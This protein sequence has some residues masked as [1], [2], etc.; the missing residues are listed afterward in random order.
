VLCASASH[1][2]YHN[3]ISYTNAILWR[4]FMTDTVQFCICVL[5]LLQRGHKPT[6][7]YILDPQKHKLHYFDLLR[8][9]CS[10]CCTVF[11]ITNL[12]KYGLKG[13]R[14]SHLTRN[15][16]SH[17]NASKVITQCYDGGV[18]V[19]QQ[20][21]SDTRRQVKMLPNCWRMRFVAVSEILLVIDQHRMNDFVRSPV[22]LHACRP[23]C[24]CNNGSPIFRLF[25]PR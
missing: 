16:H 6:I 3:I 21:A 8:T 10:T 5:E 9:C 25:A 12:V 11:C 24:P 22:C 7:D 18:I 13:C 15:G 20:D 19:S 4:Y 17:N 2:S 1:S 14:S 23:R